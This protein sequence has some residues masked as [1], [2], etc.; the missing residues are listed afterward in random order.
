M[1]PQSFF[2][3]SFPLIWPNPSTRILLVLILVRFLGKTPS[4]Q[5]RP[6]WICVPKS[7]SSD[8][9][10]RMRWSFLMRCMKR[11]I[12]RV[13]GSRIV[14]LYPRTLAPASWMEGAVPPLCVCIPSPFYIFCQ[15]T[16]VQ[17]QGLTF[18]F[19]VSTPPLFSCP[20]LVHSFFT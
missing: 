2:H 1:H 17:S 8:E 13:H 18:I 12:S 16:E 7:R 4:V 9:S 5:G 10:S 14:M 3:A 6:W 15:E 11:E 20:C 19:G